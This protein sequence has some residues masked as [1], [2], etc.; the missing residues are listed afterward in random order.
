MPPAGEAN[1]LAHLLARAVPDLSGQRRCCAWPCWARRCPVV[2]GITAGR[3]S[4]TIRIGRGGVRIDNGIAP[5]AVLVVE[6]DVEP[7]LQLATGH[8]V[9]EIASL[10]VKRPQ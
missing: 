7:L 3:T 6:G 10:R 4:A 8:L 1:L 2:L 5:D 9:R